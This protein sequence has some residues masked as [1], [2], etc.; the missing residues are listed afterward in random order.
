MGAQV[1]Q[2]VNFDRVSTLSE[3]RAL[4]RAERER[5]GPDAWIRGFAFEYAVLAGAT[6]HHDLSTR[7]RDPVRC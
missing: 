5:V 7:P 2:G 1:S 6:Y 4:L 3:V